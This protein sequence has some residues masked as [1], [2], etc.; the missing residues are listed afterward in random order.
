[1]EQDKTSLLATVREML[2]TFW[3]NT[4]TLESSA[5]SMFIDNARCDALCLDF[6]EK[7]DVLLIVVNS[8]RTWL[9]VDGHLS[10]VTEDIAYSGKN[11]LER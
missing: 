4:T 10:D 2:S 1:M 3:K 9:P 6:H 5:G 11:D 7:V 8:R